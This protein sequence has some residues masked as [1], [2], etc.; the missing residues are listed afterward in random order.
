MYGVVIILTAPPPP[1]RTKMKKT[2]EATEALLDKEFHDIY[3][4]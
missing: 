3:G 4:I 2:N 1:F